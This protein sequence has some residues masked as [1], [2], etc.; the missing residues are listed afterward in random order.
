[1]EVLVKRNQQ[2]RRRSVRREGKNINHFFP[3]E[4]AAPV[5]L[6]THPVNI[7]SVLG[8]AAFV[9]FGDSTRFAGISSSLLP[10]SN[11]RTRF[12]LVVCAV[13]LVFLPPLGFSAAFVLVAEGGSFSSLFSLLS[14]ECKSCPLPTYLGSPHRIVGS[15]EFQE[16]RKEQPNCATKLLPSHVKLAISD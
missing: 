5:A 16:Q 13:F 2:K 12:V 4:E 10:S 14:S 7:A 11:S 8:L 6:F 15:H 9:F 1:M 3:F